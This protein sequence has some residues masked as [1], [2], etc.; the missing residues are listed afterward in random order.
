MLIPARKDAIVPSPAQLPSGSDIN[1]RMAD[2]PQPTES[3]DWRIREVV[4]HY[5]GFDQLRPL[6]T[7][8]IR[9]SVEHRDSLVV[10]PTGGG[11]SLCYQVPPAVANRTDVVISPLIALMKDQVD[12][13]KAA[14][15]P[16]AAL[17][18]GMSREEQREV[19]IGLRRGEY[20]LLF[21][22]PERVLNSWFLGLLKTLNVKA[23]AID[24]AHCI[25][26]WG[27]D[28]RLEYRQLAQLRAHFPQASFHAFTA[29]A[30]PR[31]QQDIVDQLQLRDPVQLIGQFDRP[32]LIY[33]ILPKMDEEAQVVEAIRRHP[34]EAVI[35]YCISRKDT[36]QLAAVLRANR[37]KA[38][39][40]HAG[41]DAADRH[42]T[43]DDFS[44]EKIDV[45]VATVAFGMGIDRSDVRCVIHS[46]I[47]KTIEHYQQ[48][49]GR[50]GR[51]GLEAECVMLYTYADVAT[52]ERLIARSA[53][54][55]ENPKE[56][57]QA[58]TELLD[59]IQTFASTP[60]CRHRSLSE[61]F[62][63]AYE[64]P[65]CGACD[66]CLEDVEGYEDG[67]VNA[68]KILSCVARVQQRFGV[69]HVVDVLCGANTDM[70]RR[71]GHDKLTTFGLLKEH[72]KEQVTNMVFQLVDQRLLV[73][74]PGDRPTLQLNEK[75]W[76]VMKG[77]LEVKLLRPKGKKLGRTQQAE[78]SWE[79]VHRDLFEE[80]RQWRRRVADQRGVPPFVIFDDNVLREL[81]RIRPTRQETLLLV[82]GIGDRRL[83]DFGADLSA[84]ISQ[85]CQANQVETDVA[86]EAGIA[87]AEKKGVVSV[88][89]SLAFKLF[90]E[91]TAVEVVAQ[92]I[93]RAVS[94]TAGYLTEF[95][96]ERKPADVRAWV[97]DATYQR[98]V[99]AMSEDGRLAPISEK[100]GGSVPYEVIKIV[101]AHQR[102]IHDMKFGKDGR[103]SRA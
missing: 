86:A 16:A 3:L 72:A 5:W 9:A 12:G 19:E 10:M 49:T 82:R 13:L 60:R 99:A 25:S 85:F 17:H 66:V 50:A 33:R 37:I 84:I 79:G 4:R 88:A 71:C 62:G 7:E 98:V 68:Q 83:A 93:A 78:A 77:K 65:N 76:D 6:Q 69:G 11:K 87:R 41:M 2:T 42:R 45:V 56:V 36:E 100:L 80:L 43:Q 53:E 29:T 55:A 102:I 27:H 21:V 89:K 97:D 92:Q 38:A 8:A 24:E 64:R 74:T 67:T 58:Q 14:G 75:S 40:Y 1:G 18:G 96:M 28:F 63:Q 70:I 35:V 31:V 57:T 23:F 26:Q 95:L 51:D 61:Y 22:A 15:F 59:A 90:A 30:T 47:P 52:W 54:N 103:G 91:G 101:V 48:E 73:R 46:A 94:T 81:A 20:R 39:H 32:N 44:Q 34:N